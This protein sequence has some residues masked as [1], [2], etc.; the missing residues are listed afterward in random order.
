M[1]YHFTED[2]FRCKCSAN[3][4]HGCGMDIE[5]NFKAI[6]YQARELAEIPFVINSGARCQ[7]YNRAIGGKDTS[8]HTKGLAIDIKASGSRERFLICK[9]FSSLGVTRFGIDKSFIHVDI[10]REKEQMVTWLY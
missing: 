5:D 9:H 8:S 3:N 6:I 7:E 2:E 1:S 4:G 10:D